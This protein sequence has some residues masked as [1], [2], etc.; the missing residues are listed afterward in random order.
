MNKSTTYQKRNARL[1]SIT[2]Q[3]KKT[4]LYLLKLPNRTSSPSLCISGNSLPGKHF[5]R[6]LREFG[7]ARSLGGTGGESVNS[8]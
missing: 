7:V 6:N 1:L 5:A 8:D 2:I 3:V 4:K